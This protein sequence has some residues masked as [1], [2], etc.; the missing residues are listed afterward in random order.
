[1][2]KN[3]LWHYPRSGSTWYRYCIEALTDRPTNGYLTGRDGSS[4][5]NITNKELMSHK[6]E[7]VILYRRGGHQEIEYQHYDIEN[8][9]LILLLRNYKECI[10]RHLGYWGE[11]KKITAKDL[12]RFIQETDGSRMEDGDPFGL[13]YMANVI[14]YDEWKGEKSVFYYEDFMTDPNSVL[15]ETLSFLKEDV[16]EEKFNEFIENY[17]KHKEDSLQL[18][19]KEIHFTMTAGKPLENALKYHSQFIPPQIRV[20]WDNYLISKFEDIYIKYLDRYK[21]KQ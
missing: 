4:S 11:Q 17:E 13:D 14:F 7:D 3:W 6:S 20:E 15:K 12:P 9:R 1:M 10:P 21:E 2:N 16:S 5:F 19:R 8:D 18:Y